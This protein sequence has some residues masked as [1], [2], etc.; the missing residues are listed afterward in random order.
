VAVLW[1]GSTYYLQTPVDLQP[2]IRVVVELK[3][4]KQHGSSVEVY[5]HAW[6]VV[7]LDESALAPGLNVELLRPPVDLK[8]KKMVVRRVCPLC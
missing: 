3:A 5:T 8:F 7:H 1:Y 2:D 4:H 6:G